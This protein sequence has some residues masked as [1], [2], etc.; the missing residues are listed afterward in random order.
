MKCIRGYYYCRFCHLPFDY[1]GGGFLSQLKQIVKHL[2]K[3]T[4]YYRLFIWSQIKKGWIFIITDY[5]CNPRG[6]I[7]AQTWFLQVDCYFSYWWDSKLYLP[8]TSWMLLV[9]WRLGCR[10]TWNPK[11]FQVSFQQLQELQSTCRDHFITLHVCHS[12]VTKEKNGIISLQVRDIIRWYHMTRDSRSNCMTY[13]LFVSLNVFPE[14]Q[15][16]IL[17]K[18]LSPNIHSQV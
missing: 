9:S 4:S 5:S 14:I 18:V 1:S 6:V 17:L 3:N 8:D 16:R 11:F 2:W 7:Q 15:Q 13:C 12:Q 10:I